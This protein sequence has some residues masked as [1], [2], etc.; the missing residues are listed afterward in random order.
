ME[1]EWWMEMEWV[2][3]ALFLERWEG[4]WSLGRH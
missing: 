2:D 3:G 4:K 1:M